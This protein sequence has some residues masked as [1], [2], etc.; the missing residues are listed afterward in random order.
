MQKQNKKELRQCYG[1]TGLDCKV[2]G[3]KDKDPNKPEPEPEK[4]DTEATLQ[5]GE[6]NELHRSSKT[7]T[8]V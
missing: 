3:C 5:Q 8:T 1:C 6:L 2:K 7:Q 4:P